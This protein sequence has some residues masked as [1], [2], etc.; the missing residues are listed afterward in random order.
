MHNP[1]GIYRNTFAHGDHLVF[2]ALLAQVLHEKPAWVTSLMQRV[3]TTGQFVVLAAIAGLVYVESKTRLGGVAIWFDYL[4]SAL[5]STSLVAVIGLGEGAV[6]RGFARKWPRFLGQITY[7]G[8]VFHMYAVA[9]AWFAFNR[10]TQ[11]V[12]VAAPLRTLLALV[13]TFVIAYVVRVTFEARVLAL[14]A[15]FTRLAPTE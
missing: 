2:G 14:K 1:P 15:R 3:K 9:V 7:A 4:L 11:D 8:Y 5:L 6:S 13:L 10:V 12:R